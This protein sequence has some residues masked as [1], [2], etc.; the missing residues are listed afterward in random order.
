M[1]Q[2]IQEQSILI[3]TKLNWE[4]IQGLAVIKYLESIIQ[5]E[6][7]QSEQ[8][9]REA[10]LAVYGTIPDGHRKRDIK[11]E[12]DLKKIYLSKEV[13]NRKEWCGVKVGPPKIEHETVIDPTALFHVCVN[14]LQR[15]GV[16]GKNSMIEKIVP[17]PEDFEGDGKEEDATE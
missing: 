11:L 7:N 6:G 8:Q 5:P 17:T 13:D 3:G 9:V 16:I 15:T 2:N 4:Y 14:H 12:D 10:A 1:S